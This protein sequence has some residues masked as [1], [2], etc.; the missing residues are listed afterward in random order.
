MPIYTFECKECGTIKEVLQSFNASSPLCE[1]CN[2]KKVMVR[3]MS[4]TGKPKFEGSGFYETDYKQ[5]NTESKGG[6]KWLM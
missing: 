2:A 3:L 6:E 5:K 4:V 1:K